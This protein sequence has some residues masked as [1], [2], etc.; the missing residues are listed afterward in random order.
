[1]Q[2]EAL[3]VVRWS[4]T[5]GAKSASEM[6]GPDASTLSRLGA[7]LEFSA[8]TPVPD[9]A[10]GQSLSLRTLE[11]TFKHGMQN[12]FATQPMTQLLEAQK[13]GD[14]AGMT[15][16][17]ANL[18]DVSNSVGLLGKITSAVNNGVKTLTTAS[19]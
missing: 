9:T 1:M 18:V 17:L 7:H 3:S 16:A 2:I 15:I 10:L 8:A 5:P 11:S 13:R 19:G 6:Q 4:A 12:S 14:T